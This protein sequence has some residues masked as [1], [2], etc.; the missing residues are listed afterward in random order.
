MRIARY[1]IRAGGRSGRVVL[2]RSVRHTER[3]PD[4]AGEVS[5][6]RACGS[7]DTGFEEAS[8]CPAG[9]QTHP[10]AV[11]P[12]P[13]GRPASALARLA[14]PYANVTILPL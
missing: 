9:A 3:A 2:R 10:P 12:A 5:I 14:A 6:I 4:V 7:A 1:L 11:V 8:Q 13:P